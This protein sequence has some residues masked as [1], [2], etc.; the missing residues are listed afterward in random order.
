MAILRIEYL[1]RTRKSKGKL[2]RY[3]YKFR[4][5][6]GTLQFAMYDSD[7]WLPINTCYFKDEP[8][9]VEIIKKLNKNPTL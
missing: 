7:I 9:V 2:I 5:K 1:T 4:N 6:D 8:E 3:D